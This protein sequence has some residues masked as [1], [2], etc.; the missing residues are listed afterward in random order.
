M[1]L[2]FV[3][4]NVQIALMSEYTITCPKN[5][6]CH[7]KEVPSPFIKD[8]YLISLRLSPPC[9]KIHSLR[10]HTILRKKGR[11][12]AITFYTTYQ[13]TKK[14]NAIVENI[15]DT[16]VIFL[17]S[18]WL[19]H[20]L[21]NFGT[22]MPKRLNELLFSAPDLAPPTSTR[23]SSSSS[24]LTPASAPF[25]PRPL[26]AKSLAD[27]GAFRTCGGAF[28]TATSLKWHGLL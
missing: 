12:I 16:Y 26:L 27:R 28:W 10:P 9:S 4:F 24:R 19:D 20:S 2:T 1:R 5:C 15:V 21:Q 18:S 6:H 25:A 7:F 17:S 14:Q 3:S 13:T 22:L 11:R 8:R 23:R